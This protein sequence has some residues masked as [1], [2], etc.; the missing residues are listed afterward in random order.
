[1]K[2]STLIALTNYFEATDIP[3][4]LTEAVADLKAEREKNE[5]KAQANRDLYASAHDAVLAVITDTPQTVADIY[6]ACR[7]SLPFGFSKNKV[8][9][10]L[11]NYWN[12]EVEKIVVAKGANEY[13]IKG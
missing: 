7:D 11:L 4:E 3:A 10:A 1:M 6:E 12:D 9:Y 8:Q 5:E 2:K 13:K